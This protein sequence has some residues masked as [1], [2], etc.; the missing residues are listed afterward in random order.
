MSGPIH[1]FSHSQRD[2]IWSRGPLSNRPQD[3]H[4]SMSIENPMARNKRKEFQPQTTNNRSFRYWE[5]GKFVVYEKRYCLDRQIHASTHPCNLTHN[6]ETFTY[7]HWP[8][9]W[10][11]SSLWNLFNSCPQSFFYKRHALSPSSSL[12]LTIHSL[13]FKLTAT[14][15]SFL[16]LSQISPTSFNLQNE[17]LCYHR[18]P[19]PRC[20]GHCRP[21]C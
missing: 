9:I 6:I 7:P 20:S 1:Y 14:P 10:R 4:G 12:H 8:Y 15:Y 18:H 5:A 13:P 16:L 17:V 2:I 21:N 3:N 11:S 19:Q